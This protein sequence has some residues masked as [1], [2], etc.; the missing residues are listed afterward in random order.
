LKES[1]NYRRGAYYGIYPPPPGLSADAIWSFGRIYEKE[2]ETRP[3][4]LRKTKKGK[5]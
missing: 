1:G 5:R 3:K 4:S 2:E